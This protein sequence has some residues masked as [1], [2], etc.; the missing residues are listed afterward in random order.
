MLSTED[1]P[2]R[3][4]LRVTPDALSSDRRVV[5]FDV[6][7]TLLD[8]MGNLRA[9]WDRWSLAMD[10]DPDVVWNIA[11]SGLPTET[12]EIVAGSADPTECLALFHSIEDED[13]LSGRCE[14]H[15]GARQLLRRLDYGSWAVVTS[16]YAHRVLMRFERCDLPVPEVIVDAASVTRGKPNPEG[17]IRAAT[18]LDAQPA[19]SLVIEDATSGI[20]A[21]VSAGMTVWSV[22]STTKDDVTREHRRF[23]RLIDAIEEI[24]AWQRTPRALRP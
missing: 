23:P 12:F 5:L 7:G 22:N 16:N 18:L 21:G 3:H 24:V 15:E 17:Y 9:V 11:R 4:H 19:N 6:D 2:I 14:P 13:A 20:V 8:N 10:L 1:H